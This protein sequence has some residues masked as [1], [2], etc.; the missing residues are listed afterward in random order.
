MTVKDKVQRAAAAAVLSR[1]I[2]YVRKDPD[3]NLVKL[4]DRS[5][6]FVGNLFPAKNFD[7][8]REGAKDPENVWRQLALKLIDEI[9]DNVLMNMM[10]ALGLGAGVNGTKTVR[11]N[12]EKYHCNIPWVILLDPTSACNR[13]CK[14]CWS[15]EYGHKQSLTFDELNSIVNQGAAMGTH[16]YM[17]TGGEPL[18]R[19]KDL[20]RLCE[21][22]PDCAF[23]S[24]T[25]ADLVDEEFCEEM[26]RVGNISLAISIEGTKDSNDARRGEGS[27]DHVMKAMDLLKS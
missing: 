27:Y 1:M 20:I 23:L 17:F 25:N 8:F 13:K 10:L 21:L 4:V 19:K 6:R 15:A 24:Y 2:K 9:D 11:A 7:S 22:H 14:G 26:K 12:R 18:L 3:T 5:E 16:F